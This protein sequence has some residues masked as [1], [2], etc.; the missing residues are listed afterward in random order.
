MAVSV[1]E[2]MD[3][4]LYVGKIHQ[5]LHK[6]LQF[7]N[8]VWHSTSLQSVYVKL[9][10]TSVSQECLRKHFSWRFKATTVDV[11]AAPSVMTDTVD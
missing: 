11:H 8:L 1:P 5:R 2:I 4:S 3:G 7:N 6:K 10:F 9:I